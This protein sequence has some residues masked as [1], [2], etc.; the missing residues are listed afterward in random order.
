MINT[1]DYFPAAGAMRILH[2]T[3]NTLY[4]ILGDQLGSTSVVT[5]ASG[6]VVGTQPFDKLRIGATIPSARRAT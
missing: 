4:Y 6:V 2:H 5:N 1:V 3:E